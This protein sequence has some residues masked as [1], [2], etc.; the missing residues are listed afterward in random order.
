MQPKIAVPAINLHG[1]VD[2]VA[3]AFLSEGHD[4]FFT[5]PYQRRVLD[6]VGH[7]VP[8]EAPAAFAE[9]VLELC[10]RSR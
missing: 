6:H 10:P 2:G 5:G 1:S 3:P 7:N 9:A 8:Q 4:R